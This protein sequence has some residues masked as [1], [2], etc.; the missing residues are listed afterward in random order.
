M[1]N[2]RQETRDRRAKLAFRQ[3]VRMLVGLAI[4]VS[5]YALLAVRPDTPSDWLMIR[6]LA[7]FGALVVGFGVAI[8]PLLE[9]IT[10]GDDY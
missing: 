1:D 2:F 3:R 8:L 9:K 7:G 4:L 6:V 5:G 10:G